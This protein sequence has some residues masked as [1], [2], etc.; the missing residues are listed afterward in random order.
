MNWGHE[1]NLKDYITKITIHVVDT[2]HQH[3]TACGIL[4]VLED[5][6]P[7]TRAAEEARRRS[8]IININKRMAWIGGSEEPR[9]GK[10]EKVAKKNRPR[11][12]YCRTPNIHDGIMQFI[13]LAKKK[14]P[15]DL[16]KM[17]GDYLYD[18]TFFYSTCETPL[19]VDD[20][21]G[22]GPGHVIM[23]FNL[24]GTGL[25]VFNVKYSHALHTYNSF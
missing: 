20:Y 23:N 2:T 12:M 8:K 13:R 3:P 19:H 24:M 25:L 16:R 7:Q 5:D 17:C 9:L 21:D 14:L 22:D 1:S 4:E 11:R 6:G 18:I 15:E 10:K